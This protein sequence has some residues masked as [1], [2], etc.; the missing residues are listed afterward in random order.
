MSSALDTQ[1]ELK[2]QVLEPVPTGYRD[3]ADAEFSALLVIIRVF[4]RFRINPALFMRIYKKIVHAVENV[5][6]SRMGS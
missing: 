2:R 5:V 1:P 3:S 6:Q 4:V